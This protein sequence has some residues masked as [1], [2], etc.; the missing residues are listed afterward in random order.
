ML[1]RNWTAR[2]ALGCRDS[3]TVRAPWDEELH[4][5]TGFRANAPPCHSPS[6]PAR[7]ASAPGSRWTASRRFV[8]RGRDDP[9]LGRGDEAGRDPRPAE[10]VDLRAPELLAGLEAGD[11]RDVARAER[12]P[13]ADPDGSELGERAGLDRKYQLGAASL[14]VDQD[15]LLA[16]LGQREPLLAERDLQRD[17]GGDHVLGDDRIAGLDRERLAQPGRLRSRESRPGS[18][19]TGTGMAP[20]LGREHDR[21]ALP[22]RSM[23][24][25][26]IAFVIAWLRSSSASSS[27]GARAAVDLAAL[28]A[29]LRSL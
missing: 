6:S 28:A 19:T 21:S 11:V 13:A 9:H 17:V 7:S 16:D 12:R 18:S 29:S 5:A 27:V 2:A 4:A 25:S 10:I 8:R 15:L 20:R 23:R 22:V 26:T 1:R 3:A 24:G 14:V